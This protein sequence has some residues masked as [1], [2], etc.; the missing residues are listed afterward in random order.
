MS[1]TNQTI[2]NLEKLS[3]SNE[4]MEKYFTVCQPEFLTYRPK[5]HQVMWSEMDDDCLLNELG[6]CRKAENLPKFYSHTCGVVIWMSADGMILDYDELFVRETPTQV[7]LSMERMLCASPER[8]EFYK[9]LNGVGELYTFVFYIFFHFQS[10]TV[11]I[12]QQYRL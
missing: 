1:L 2:L 4:D 11:Y 5:A 6:A 12:S 9:R 7:L 8:I 3:S 10:F